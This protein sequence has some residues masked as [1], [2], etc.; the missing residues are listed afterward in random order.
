[1]KKDI[2]QL[3]FKLKEYLK[4][5]KQIPTTLKNLIYF[6]KN[7]VYNCQKIKEKVRYR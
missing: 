4:I 5:K 2:K 1:M 6:G 3:Y 7:F